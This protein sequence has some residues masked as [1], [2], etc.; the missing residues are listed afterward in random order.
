MPKLYSDQN[1]WSAGQW[2]IMKQNLNLGFFFFFN[3]KRLFQLCLG[4]LN[5]VSISFSAKMPKLYF[6]QNSWSTRLMGIR[7]KN[8]NL[9]FFLQKIF[10]IVSWTSKY[11]IYKF[12][13]KNSEIVFWSKFL[14]RGTKGGCGTNLNLVSFSFSTKDFSNWFWDL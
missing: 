11:G 13:C 4:P 8:L 7:E 9:V 3:C 1:S 6:G 12:S 5:M 14:V 10:P 2:G